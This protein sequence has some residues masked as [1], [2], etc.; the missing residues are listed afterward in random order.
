MM[1]IANKNN[2]RLFEKC[3][4]NECGRDFD[5]MIHKFT[6]E[7]LC[8]DCV[9]KKLEALIEEEEADFRYDEEEPTISDLLMER[10]K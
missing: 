9:N 1:R 3:G 6:D 10:N 7:I 2:P 5:L 4:C 8:V